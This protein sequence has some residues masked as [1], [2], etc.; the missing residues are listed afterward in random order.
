[1]RP[2][3]GKWH[4]LA[5]GMGLPTRSASDAYNRGDKWKIIPR[6]IRSLS[7]QKAK[8][9]TR[10]G[11]KQLF[12]LSAIGSGLLTVRLDWPFFFW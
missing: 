3:E 5:G 4:K 1:M 6:S 8:K 12:D 9:K 10:F 2:H 11:P 7:S